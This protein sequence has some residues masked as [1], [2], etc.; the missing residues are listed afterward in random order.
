MVEFLLLIAANGS[1]E[2]R[3]HYRRMAALPGIKRA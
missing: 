2:N 3:R 1:L